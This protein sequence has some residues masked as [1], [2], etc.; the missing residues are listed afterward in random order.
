VI[1]GTLLFYAATRLLKSAG[2][3][4]IEAEVEAD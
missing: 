1:S 2:L 4:D 3:R